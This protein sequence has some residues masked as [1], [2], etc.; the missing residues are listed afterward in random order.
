MEVK[1]EVK[2]PIKYAVMPIEEQ[3]GWY[4]GLNELEREYSVVANI[5]SKCYVIRE[6]KEYLQ[7]GTL[8]IK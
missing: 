7:D 1:K 6:D 5:V 3:I 2:Y 8:K 4:P